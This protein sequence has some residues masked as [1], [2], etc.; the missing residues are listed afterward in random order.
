MSSE[1]FQR[2]MDF[3]IEQQAR[4]SADIEELKE[5]QKKQAA[6]L[7]RLTTDVQS[8]TTGVQSLTTDV[9]SLTTDVQS[10]TQVVGVNIED[11]HEAINNLIIANEVTR[12]LAENV[13]K[14]VIAL[15]QRVTALESR[16]NGE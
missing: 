4:F 8:L 7:D 13:A 11:T 14:L 1:H 16:E 10:L 15:S 2:Q 9:Q 6:N 5:V 3:I 12:N